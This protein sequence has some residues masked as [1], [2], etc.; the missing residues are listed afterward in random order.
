MIGYSGVA[1]G[2]PK[3]SHDATVADML[4][5]AA[6]RVETE[7]ADQPEVKAEMLGTIAG[8][9]LTQSKLD[10]A[11]RYS[12]E[13]YALNVKLYGQDGRQTAAAMQGL[14][15]LAYLTGD[16]LTAESWFRKALPIYR[17]HANDPDFEVR[18]LVAMLSD[19]AFVQRA[20]GKPGDAEALWREALTYGP[21]LPARNHGQ[22]ISPKTFL[23]QLYLDHGD[24]AKADVLASEASHD[25][26]AF[27]SDRFLLARSLIDLGDVRSLEGRYAEADASIE[28]GTRLYAQAQGDG[29]PNVAYG[30]LRLAESH[31]RQ[32]KYS[33]A[34]QDTRKAL[35]IVEKLPDDPRRIGAAD[36][37]LGLIFVKTGR[38]REAEPLLR[39]ALTIGEQKSPRRSKYMATALGGLGECLAAQKRYAEAE[40]LLTE[41][42]EILGS[43]QVPQSPALRG[44][45]ER[46]EL[47]HGT[48]EGTPEAVPK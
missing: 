30:L 26:R 18:Q 12:N 23:A 32:A 17:R 9:Y 33:L 13:A 37:S 5:D 8:T 4:D 27:G 45:R 42:Y 44:A 16:Y 3:H 19:A 40:L 38:L 22:S 28:E 20:L 7:L 41:S 35:A 29:H 6:Q 21:R 10:R 15:V 25:L 31:Y 2:T 48:R 43:L 46:L 47:L 36:I 34:E 39:K 1:G 14:G 11:A 24:I